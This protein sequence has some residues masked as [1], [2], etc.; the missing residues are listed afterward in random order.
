M[1]SA[2]PFRNGA[3]PFVLPPG[4]TPYHHP[5]VLGRA[6]A[7]FYALQPPTIWATHAYPWFKIGLHL[8]L[9]DCELTVIENGTTRTVTLRGEQAC[10]FGS[11]EAHG[12]R[13]KT[14]APMVWIFVAEDYLQQIGFDHITGVTC[15]ELVRL[16]RHERP[17]Q[18]EVVVRS[19]TGLAQRLL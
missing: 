10:F 6:V 4:S 8:G 13:W 3:T 18:G 9:A 17:V 11:R 19:V 14:E 2:S 15:V 5:A 1:G 12:I 7:I 16:I